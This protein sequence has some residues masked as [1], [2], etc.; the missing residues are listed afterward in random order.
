M[1]YPVFLTRA[2]ARYLS[3][4]A[5]QDIRH[6]ESRDLPA[7]AARHRPAWRALQ[8]ACRWGKEAG[9]R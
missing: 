5:A 3:V 4:L 2:D 1:R 6:D 9:H 7:T 8:R